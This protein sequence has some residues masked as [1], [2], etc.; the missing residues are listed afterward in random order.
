MKVE[1]SKAFK[2]DI[3]KLNNQN[4]KQKLKEVIIRLENEESLRI[5]PNCIK[6]QNHTTAY[7]I[8]IG[9]YRLGIYYDNSEIQLARFVK[10][11]D[12]YKLF[13]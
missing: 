5:I 9:G 11:N 2:K 10:R 7:R 4:V 6:F 8:R 12:I 13:P 1:F 3:S